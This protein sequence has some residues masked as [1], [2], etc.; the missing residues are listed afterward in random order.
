MAIANK[1]EPSSLVKLYSSAISER[2]GSKVGDEM[3]RYFCVVTDAN[4][5]LPE[6]VMTRIIQKG[7]KEFKL[8]EDFT[9]F[10]LGFMG[11][12]VSDL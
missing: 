12:T 5:N 3:W 6:S 11:G 2:Y 4:G 9:L 7:T 8:G 1:S 10:S